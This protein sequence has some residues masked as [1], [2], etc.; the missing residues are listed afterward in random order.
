MRAGNAGCVAVQ[1]NITRIPTMIIRRDATTQNDPFC[2]RCSPPLQRNKMEDLP[3][4][5]LCVQVELRWRS[6]L[7]LSG[8]FHGP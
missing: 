8:A 2:N 6:D 7:Q 5:V 4:D 3:D 1:K